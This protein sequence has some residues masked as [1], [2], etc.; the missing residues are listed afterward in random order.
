MST[1]RNGVIQLK[2]G[3]LLATLRGDIKR[4]HKMHFAVSKDQGKTWSKVYS[5]GY[6]D[7]CPHVARLSNS[8]IV[9]TYR[10]FT[11]D[12]TAESGYT[13]LR[14][15]YDEGKTWQ[16]QY[17]IDKFCDAYASTVE[18]ADKSLLIT[19]YEEGNQ[20]DVHVIRTNAPKQTNKTWNYANPVPL[21]RLTF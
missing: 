16:E 14:I 13:G 11:D 18:L 6:Q 9:L 19:Y 7:H 15:S 2:N 4:D 21:K 10:A 8:A 20:S 17:L 5:A 12:L 1:C 3:D